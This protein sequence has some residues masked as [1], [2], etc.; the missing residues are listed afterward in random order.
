MDVSYA[1]LL[2]SGLA[3]WNIHLSIPFLFLYLASVFQF[4]FSHSTVPSRVRFLWS[5]LAFLFFPP[6][7]WV[8]WYIN[9]CLSMQRTWFLQ[10]KVWSSHRYTLRSGTSVGSINS[11]RCLVF[12]RV[13]SINT[14]PLQY[15]PVWEGVSCWLSKRS[16]NGGSS[17]ATTSRLWYNFFL[18]VSSTLLCKALTVFIQQELPKGKWLCCAD[19]K[20]INLALQKL[21]DRGEEKLPETSL[22]VIK[23]KHEESGS[24]NAVDF[25]VRWRVLRGKKVDAS[26]GTRALLSK[27]VSIFHVGIFVFVWLHNS[28]L[29]YEVGSS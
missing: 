11:L 10:V 19:C 29:R 28:C 4:I 18:A 6:W 24:D 23:K 27:A 1:G 2:Y 22:D 15:Y 21:V 25:D 3:A 5:L 17:G 14:V 9:I 7:T 8:L 16:W 26:D 12:S 20:R 13:L